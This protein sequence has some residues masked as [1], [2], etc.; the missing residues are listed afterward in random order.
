[1]KTQTINITLEDTYSGDAVGG[2]AMTVVSLQAF[3]FWKGGNKL[4]KKQK[5]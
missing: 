1:M 3:C 2:Y 5:R 4:W